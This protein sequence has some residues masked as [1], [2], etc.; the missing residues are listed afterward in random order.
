MD[1][2][3]NGIF[4]MS[5]SKVLK[6]NAQNLNCIY[7]G[8]IM[9]GFVNY[10]NTWVRVHVFDLCLHCI[11]LG[12]I[13]PRL[14]LILCFMEF[15]PKKIEEGVSNKKINKTKKKFW[16]KLFFLNFFSKIFLKNMTGGSVKQR[17]EN[18][19]TVALCKNHLVIHMIYI[20]IYMY[21]TH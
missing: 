6:L 9:G 19:V 3:S 14:L 5:V 4:I 12:I 10:F 17:F 20:L 21:K 2:G 18:Q 8:Y 15:F 11:C 16:G 13:R 7:R 1:L